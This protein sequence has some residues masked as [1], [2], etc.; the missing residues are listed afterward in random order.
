MHELVYTFPMEITVKE[1]HKKTQGKD[2]YKKNLVIDVRVPGEYRVEHMPSSTN[3]P[4]DE[5]KDHADELK[6]YE[7]I[8]IHC[9]TGGRSATACA[10]LSDLG[11]DN[12]VNVDGGITAW[13]EQD[14]PT[15]QGRGISMQRQIMIGAGSLVLV[16]TLLSFVFPLFVLLAV[17]VGA[18]LLFAGVTGYCGMAMLL[19]HAPWNR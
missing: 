13:K 17:F 14:L 1:L 11:L 12:W 18:G 2:F 9:E 6:K 10:T 19:R 3:I 7:T 4:L 5:I 8:Y 16:G 15:I